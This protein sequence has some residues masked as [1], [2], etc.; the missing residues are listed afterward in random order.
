MGSPSGED[1]QV[2]LDWFDDDMPRSILSS[3]R[4]AC[5]DSSGSSRALPYWCP[6][7]RGSLF[8]LNEEGLQHAGEA[9]DIQVYF[10]KYGVN[11]S[12]QENGSS[13]EMARHCLF[14]TDLRRGYL[15]MEVKKNKLEDA[16]KSVEV[17]ARE[18]EARHK[19]N[20][21]AR[22]AELDK[23][24]E[25]N[26]DLLVKNRDLESKRKEVNDVYPDDGEEGEEEEDG[27]GEVEGDVFQETIITDI[28]SS[29]QANTVV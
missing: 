10:M 8:P 21:E 4:G 26:W 28:L 11:Y 16:P 23:L 17:S 14:P 12:L 29:Q 13:R 18:Q 22:E 20:V 25:E 9:L 3:L 27:V 6:S 7:E 15:E 24:K 2:S 19:V 1:I 5:F